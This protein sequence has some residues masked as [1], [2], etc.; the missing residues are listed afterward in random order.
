MRY[1]RVSEL[2]DYVIGLMRHVLAGGHRAVADI[3][4]HIPNKRCA[5]DVVRERL[6]ASRAGGG[7]EPI[8]S[9]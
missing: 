6:F 1:H 8:V 5:F 2:L 9:V 4:E 7:E 3:L